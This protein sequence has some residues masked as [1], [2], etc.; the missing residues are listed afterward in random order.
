MNRYQRDIDKLNMK[1][2]DDLRRATGLNYGQLRNLHKEA[3]RI[4]D[5]KRTKSGPCIPLDPKMQVT[6][7]TL[8]YLTDIVLGEVTPGAILRGDYE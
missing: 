4:V 6:A 3:V 2:Y 1:K 7:R 8:A 5:T